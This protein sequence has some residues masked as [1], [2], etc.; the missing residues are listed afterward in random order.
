MRA[1]AFLLVIGCSASVDTAVED[2]ADGSTDEPVTDTVP[3]WSYTSP[4]GMRQLPQE[5]EAVLPGVRFGLRGYDQI[6]TAATPEGAELAIVPTQNTKRPLLILSERTQ[7]RSLVWM[8]TP[9][10]LL[11]HNAVVWDDGT[12]DTGRVLYHVL[13]GGVMTATWTQAPTGSAFSVELN[14]TPVVV[15]PSIYRVGTLCIRVVA[16]RAA[17]RGR[18]ITVEATGVAQVLVYT[19]P[20]Y[21]N[22]AVDLAGALRTPR[23]GR[24]SIANSAVVE[25]HVRFTSPT[26]GID[27][28]HALGTTPSEHPGPTLLADRAELFVEPTGWR[29]SALA[30]KIIKTGPI[31]MRRMRYA[32]SSGVGGQTFNFYVF[33]PR[34][35]VTLW[36]VGRVT[37]PYRLARIED[38]VL[39]DFP[40]TQNDYS[41]DLGTNVMSTRTAWAFDAT[42]LVEASTMTA[43]VAISHTGQ[44]GNSVDGGWRHTATGP[45]TRFLVGDGGGFVART[46]P[47]NNSYRYDAGNAIQALY[48]THAVFHHQRTWQGAWAERAQRIASLQASSTIYFGTIRDLHNT[49]VLAAGKSLEVGQVL[50]VAPKA[51]DPIDLHA[52]YSL[53]QQPLQRAMLDLD[54]GAEVRAPWDLAITGDQIT[55]AFEGD[56]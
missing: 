25:K 16:G 6:V 52:R 39:A 27:H 29:I 50:H 53:A 40:A 5:D 35:T 12:A 30:V 11:W 54:R 1:L 4:P 32:H 37:E 34:G 18:V 20:H 55:V 2:P 33:S 47:S 17:L 26:L 41:E 22:A 48:P 7:S 9:L 10:G 44:E 8:L 42:T 14:V 13:E 51:E 49:D 19:D 15:S 43:N 31:G 23:P 38:V 28:V 36:P 46:P 21:D 24:V 56:D 45:L 3:T